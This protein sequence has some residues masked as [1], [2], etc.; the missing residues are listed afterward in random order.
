M[1]AN[2]DSEGQG[3]A[4]AA[5]H[6]NQHEGRSGG[7]Q[8]VKQYGKRPGLGGNVTIGGGINRSTKPTPQH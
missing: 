2:V 3:R 7:K 5:E 8:V 6:D 4:K 1:A